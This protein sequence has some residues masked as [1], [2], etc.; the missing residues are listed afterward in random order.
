MTRPTSQREA[1]LYLVELGLNDCQI[2]RAMDIPH[3]TIRG[4]RHPTYVHKVG[5]RIVDGCP[6]CHKAKLDDKAYAYLLGLYLGDG[7]LRPGRRDVFALEIYCCDRYVGLIA[8]ASAALAAVL[9][10]GWDAVG[11]QQALGVITVRG[12]WKHWPCLFPQHGPGPKHERLIIL[13]AW[14]QEIADRHPQLLLRGL[15]HSDGWRGR[16]QGR[17]QNGKLYYYP[18]YQFSNVSDDI[19]QIFRDA[20]E[21]LGVECKKSNWNTISVSR[22]E[23]VAFLDIFVGHKY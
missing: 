7:W 20:C 18:R 4:W 17:G 3:G 16:N 21:R 9:P 8:E 23:A 22:R 13:E 14:Q 15:I 10:N 12:Y 5:A 1:A 19:R 2:G 6:R 11:Y